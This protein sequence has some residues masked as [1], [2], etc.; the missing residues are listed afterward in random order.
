VPDD[1]LS[2]YPSEQLLFE[3]LRDYGFNTD[4]VHFIFE[5]LKNSQPGTSFFSPTHRVTIERDGLELTPICQ[6]H[7]FPLTLSYQQIERDSD[8]TLDPSPEVAQLDYNKL[9]F[10][11][12]IR[13]WQ[14]GD[15]FHPLG[16]KGS[17]LLSDY[18]VDQKMTTR[19]KEEC[20]VLTTAKNEIVWVVGKRIDDRFKVTD[21]TK[22]ILRV[23]LS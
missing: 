10:P 13:K 23:Q 15:R 17:K 9:T 14:A 3:W 1:S 22:M 5:A 7:D 4:Q 21:D 18:F 8:F 11:L 12:Q 6:Q 20:Q 19:Q 2:P 16:M